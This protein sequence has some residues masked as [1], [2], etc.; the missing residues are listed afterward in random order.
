MSVTLPVGQAMDRVKKVLFQPF[1]FGRWLVI[2]FCAWLAYLGEG[3]GLR[4]LLS[5]RN[6][7]FPDAVRLIHGLSRD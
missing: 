4:R 7:R 5:A 6:G 3:G 2:G 1:D